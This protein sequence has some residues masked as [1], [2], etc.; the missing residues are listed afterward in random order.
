MLSLTGPPRRHLKVAPFQDCWIL[1]IG[2]VGLFVHTHA[3]TGSEEVISTGFL[4]FFL[5]QLK[6]ESVTQILRD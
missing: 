2:T 4:P 5:T 3:P 6:F 1:D